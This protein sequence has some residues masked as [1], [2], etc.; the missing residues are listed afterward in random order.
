M[1]V[2]CRASH[3]MALGLLVLLSSAQVAP[4]NQSPAS[5]GVRNA[6]AMAYD[7]RGRRTL[8]FG[9][10][11]DRSVRSDTWIWD[12]QHHDWRPHGA[13]GPVGRTFPAMAYDAARDEMV[14]FGGNRVLFGPGTPD[15]ATFLDDTWVLQRDT[16]TRRDVAGPPPRAEAAMAYDVMRRRVV[17]FGGYA[18]TSTGRV[19][20]GDTWEWDGTQWTLTAARGPAPRNGAALAYDERDGVTVLSGGPPSLV[21]AETWEW[22]GTTW[23]QR[24]EPAPPG[25]FNPVMVYHRAVTGLLRYGGWTG[26]TRASDTWLRANGRWRELPARGPAARNHAAMAYDADRGRA[27]L[28]GGHD[29]DRVF[30]DT[31][32]F[33]GAR[34]VEAK[35]RAPEVRLQN[36]H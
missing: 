23:R 21:G 32:E 1:P 9:G 10:A 6:H 24:P 7:I 18:Q 16:W 29:G 31:W 5:I 30:G 12:H 15:P 33:D 14:L 26:T 35:R 36:G 4:G 34:W 25:R 13:E 2:G 11:D 28:F 27:V 19:R 17:L 8:L 3:R 22:D 20:Y